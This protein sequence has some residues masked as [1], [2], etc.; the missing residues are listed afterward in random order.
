[1]KLNNCKQ[2]FQRT[3]SNFKNEEMKLRG[4]KSSVDVLKREIVEGRGKVQKQD[5][6]VIALKNQLEKA[7]QEFERIQLDLNNKERQS[8]NFEIEEKKLEQ[9]VSKLK[10][11]TDTK[12]REIDDL[13]LK[14]NQILI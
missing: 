8:S 5:R 11:E 6:D 4:I 3:E 14:I 9:E 7:K 1:L 10:N 2:E 12:K 13:T